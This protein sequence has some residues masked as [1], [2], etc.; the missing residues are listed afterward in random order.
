MLGVA[1]TEVAIRNSVEVYAIVRANTNR[2]D[3]MI[4]S[5]FVHVLYGNLGSLMDIKGIPNDCDVFYHFAWA[6]TSKIERDNPF[7]Q[8]ENIRYILDA[9]ELAHCC[10]CRR[11]VGA[12]S[13]AEY[14]PVDEMINDNTK[15]SPVLAYGTA[16]LA[17]GKLSKKLCEKCGI[18]HVWGR[19][20]SVYGPHDNEGTMLKYAIT[21]WDNHSIA[22]FSSG[23][24]YWNYLYES[25][26]GEIFFRLGDAKD[27]TG[28]Y[29]VANS[30]SYPLREY[31]NILT[32]VYGDNARAEFAPTVGKKL[33]GLK[34]DARRTFS[35]INYLPRISFEEGVRKII[36]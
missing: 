14:G 16:K 30:V 18:E 27:C 17:A 11:F 33:P 4:E 32:K 24:Q 9:V 35:S 36:L 1:L 21:S 28:D 8:E 25:D 10:G 34:V 2:L 6:G 5:P 3:R 19:V 31:I 20:F 15:F 7:I 22:R 23:E 29:L 13:Q 12:G 26:A